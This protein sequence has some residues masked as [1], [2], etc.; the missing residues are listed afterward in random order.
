[1]VMSLDQIKQHDKRNAANHEAG[2]ATVAAVLGRI[3]SAW[4]VP[5]ERGGV[6][7]KC[8]FGT[9]L[10]EVLQMV[11]D[12]AGAIRFKR[13]DR[14]KTGVVG[15]AGMVAEEMESAPYLIPEEVTELWEQE[16]ISPSERDLLMAPK[17]WPA[18]RKAVLKAAHILKEQRALFTQIATELIENDFI[19]RGRMRELVATLLLVPEN[20]ESK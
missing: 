12:R 4:L 13:L 7:E 16:L 20:V 19:C 5:N 15:V 11:R 8:W 1:M 14:T 2:H 17:T 18:R 9:F 6:E 10:Y 3:G